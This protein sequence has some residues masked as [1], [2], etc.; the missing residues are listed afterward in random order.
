M[1]EI[2]KII[3]GKLRAAMLGA[4]A[5]GGTVT[6]AAIE[7]ALGYTPADDA[8]VDELKV[9][10]TQLNERVSTLENNTT[11]ETDCIFKYEFPTDFPWTDNPVFDKIWANGRGKFITNVSALDYA[12]NDG[13][14]V[15]VYISPTGLDTNSGLTQNEPKKTLA[16]A[17]N[18]SGCRR[19]HVASGSYAYENVT[20]SHDVDIIGDPVSIPVFNS[21]RAGVEWGT[22]ATPNVYGTS[23]LNENYKLFDLTTFDGWHYKQYAKVNTLTECVNA[24]W[25][26]Y[27]NTSSGR[28]YVHT[29]TGVV[30]SNDTVCYTAGF[31]ALR[32][33]GN[34]H[35]IHIRNLRFTCG[36]SFDSTNLFDVRGNSTGEGVFSAYNC[37]FDRSM[38]TTASGGSCLT[39]IEYG[40]VIMEKC[41]GFYSGRDA[42]G[43][44][45]SDVVEIK[46]CGAYGGNASNGAN[47]NGST[48][49]HCRIIRIGCSYHDYFGRIVHDV[50]NDAVTLNLGV[51]AWHS[52]LP[53]MAD[54]GIG[55]GSNAKMWL[56][57]CVSYGSDYSVEA[58]DGGEFVCAAYK[59]NMRSDAPEWH[60]NQSSIVRY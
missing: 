1:A 34:S 38:P 48:G 54:F 56:D 26:Y 6:K 27:Q 18:V 60:S 2:E 21:H 44:H 23:S 7:A 17:L 15:D 39:R 49:H 4:K 12:S 47:S 43:Y 20:L 3:S 52:L 16:S 45:N 35:K 36:G 41:Q 25:T 22:T 9:D 46:C 5:Q 42:F 55:Q 51:A 19:I 14:G 10:I 32:I 59:R 28:T 57:G 13:D 50:G 33:N 53:E 58:G 31:Y 40:N 8:D 11:D 29:P 24:E 37:I 30:A